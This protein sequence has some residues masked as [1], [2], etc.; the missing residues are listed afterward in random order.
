M[1]DQPP[2]PASFELVLLDQALAFVDPLVGAATS[3][4]VLADM[5]ALLGWNSREIGL[6]TTALSGIEDAVSRIEQIIE[7][8]SAPDAE[9][10]LGTLV[11]SLV[12][13]EE[14]VQAVIAIEQ[15]VD[16]PPPGF[17]AFP[18]QL[19]QFLTTTWLRTRHPTVYRAMTLLTLVTPAGQQP[20]PAADAVVSASGEL[21][22]FPSTQDQLAFDQLGKLLTDPVGTLKQAYVP[23]GLSGQKF[24]DKLADAVL[25]L[26]GELLQNLGAQA[27]YGTAAVGGVDLGVNAARAAHILGF[28]FAFGDDGGAGATVMLRPTPG[29]AT[30]TDIGVAPFGRRCSRTRSGRGCSSSTSARRSTRC[31][32]APTGWRSIR[33]AARSAPPC[34]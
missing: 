1:S 9:I 11:N 12:A 25:P 3:E 21:I 29:A 17:S 6:A 2:E 32:S 7:E 10:T 26:V 16:P 18:G 31:S 23:A 15:A 8:L 28:W 22:S 24:A 27:S 13:T 4:A 14:L 34:A 30:G 33:R 5:L 20:L 19:L